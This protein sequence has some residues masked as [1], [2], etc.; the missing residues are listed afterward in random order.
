M[1]GSVEP[2]L[3]AAQ[4]LARALVSSL[5]MP[6]HPV[7]CAVCGNPMQ[8]QM[9]PQGVEI[10]VCDTHGVWLLTCWLRLLLK[11]GCGSKPAG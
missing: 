6:H 7:A 4:P 5:A 11:L 1:G 10:D 3:R 9:I 2:K 8:K